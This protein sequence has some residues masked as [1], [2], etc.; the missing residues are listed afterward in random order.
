LTV[1]LADLIGKLVSD[2]PVLFA[3]RTKLTAIH[4]SFIVP[5]NL[6]C[7]FVQ[8]AKEK[9]TIGKKSLLGRFGG[10]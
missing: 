3:A 6:F 7:A 2:H 5:V 10:K 9:S 8:G 4:Y 1:F